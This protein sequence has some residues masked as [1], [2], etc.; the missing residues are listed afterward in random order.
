[1]SSPSRSASMTAKPVSSLAK[2][3][4]RIEDLVL[5]RRAG[6]VHHWHRGSRSESSPRLGRRA[7]Y[8]VRAPVVAADRRARRTPR[9]VAEITVVLLVAIATCDAPGPVGVEEHEVAGLDRGAVHRRADAELVDSSC[10]GS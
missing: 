3:S 5:E 4:R 7:P 10:A 1:M 6:R 2:R 8:V 9:V